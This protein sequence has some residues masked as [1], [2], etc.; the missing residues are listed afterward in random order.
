[1]DPGTVWRIESGGRGLTAK[2]RDD[3]ARVLEVPVA[4]LYAP[5]GSPIPSPASDLVVIDPMPYEPAHAMPAVARRLLA[6]QRLSGLTALEI[7]MRIEATEAEVVDWLEGRSLP[8]MMLMNRLARLA[9][10]TLHWL[11]HGDDKGMPAGLAARLRTLMT[12]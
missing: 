10:F 7:A 11:Y 12:G 9:G 2:W 6:V 8:P 5:I 4:Q 3:L 1:M